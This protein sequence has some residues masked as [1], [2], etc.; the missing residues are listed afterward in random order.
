MANLPNRGYFMFKPEFTKDEYENLCE[1]LMLDDDYRK[2]FKMR[3]QNKSIVEMAIEL[4]TSTSTIS[5]KL[6]KL[7]KKIKR[8]L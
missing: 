4:N 8:V 6:D 5:R 3:I 2:I 1:K 7:V